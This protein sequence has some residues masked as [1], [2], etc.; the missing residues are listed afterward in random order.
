MPQTGET[1]ALVSLPHLF[2][3]YCP[4]WRLCPTLHSGTLG[5]LTLSWPLRSTDSTL[6]QVQAESGRNS[7]S[8]LLGSSHLLSGLKFDYQ[9]NV[10][11]VHEQR[12]PE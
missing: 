1:E 6:A 3:K 7:G 4:S 5:F 2:P 9:A 11:D 8:F 10:L 12:E